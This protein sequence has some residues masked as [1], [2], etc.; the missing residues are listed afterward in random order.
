MKGLLGMDVF[1]GIA[2]RITRVPLLALEAW[3]S[4]CLLADVPY[5]RHPKSMNRKGKQTS[6]MG[7]VMKAFKEIGTNRIVLFLGNCH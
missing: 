2:T 7:M 4:Y 6:Y 5:S 3:F 1:E